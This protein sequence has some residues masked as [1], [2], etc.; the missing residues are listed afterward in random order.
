MTPT[1]LHNA[2]FELRHAIGVHNQALS[3][4]ERYKKN[5]TEACIRLEDACK[6]LKESFS[7][8]DEIRDSL[9][10]NGPK[11]MRPSL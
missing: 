6:K 1:D 11:T 2:S 10:H 7:S 4:A 8:F 9:K 3:E 5:F